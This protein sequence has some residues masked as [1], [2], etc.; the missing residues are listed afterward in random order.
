MTLEDVARMAALM[1]SCNKWTSI[2][3]MC[4]ERCH[5]G[6]QAN[7]A[8]SGPRANGKAA[9]GQPKAVLKQ[10][11]SCHAVASSDY[12]VVA[13]VEAVQQGPVA[14]VADLET[15]LQERDAC[16]VSCACHWHIKL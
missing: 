6:L 15:I 12:A 11:G 3:W 9:A 10:A 8:S 1:Q 14:N 4:W 2:G 13:D 5:T 7:H 16:G